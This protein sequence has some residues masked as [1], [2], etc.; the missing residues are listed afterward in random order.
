[1][2]VGVL[3]VV[4]KDGVVMADGVGHDVVAVVV[5][6]V[7]AAAADDDDAHTDSAHTDNGMNARQPAA[8]AGFDRVE[9]ES[10]AVTDPMQYL[11]NSP[12][13]RRTENVHGRVF[14]HCETCVLPHQD[15]ERVSNHWTSI[16]PHS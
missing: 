15:L 7:D 5:V 10:L 3:V 1:M 14:A 13:L 6:D 9:S 12:T 4:V 2:N 8:E 16:P 11:C